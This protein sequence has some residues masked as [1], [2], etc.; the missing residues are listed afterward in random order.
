MCIRDRIPGEHGVGR[1]KAPWLEQSLGSG[2][3]E[4]NLRIKAAL[5]PQGVI[6]PGAKFVTAATATEGISS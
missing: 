1:L 3:Y 5:D 6:N 4:L 2:A